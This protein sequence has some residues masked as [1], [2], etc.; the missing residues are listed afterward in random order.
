MI[1]AVACCGTEGQKWGA[2][3]PP[4]LSFKNNSGDLYNEI[5]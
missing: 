4:E 1:L 5:T 3:S 2:I